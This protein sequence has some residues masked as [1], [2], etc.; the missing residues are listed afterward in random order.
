MRHRKKGKKLGRDTAQRKALFKNLARSFFLNEGK[1]ESTLP[2][3]KAVQP[4]IERIITRARK[5][6]LD[7]RRRLY[8]IFQDQKFVNKLAESFGKKLK[9]RPGGYTKIIKLKKRRGDDATVARLELI[10]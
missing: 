1:V 9:D 10:K 2:K 4:K 8:A 3:V 7:S 6:D 5:G